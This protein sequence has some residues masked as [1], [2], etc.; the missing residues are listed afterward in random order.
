[1]AAR[2]L[3]LQAAQEFAPRSRRVDDSGV[4][5]RGLAPRRRSF[6]RHSRSAQSSWGRRLVRAEKRSKENPVKSKPVFEG[7]TLPVKASE[8]PERRGIG[9]ELSGRS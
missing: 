4:A 9:F 8:T 5:P 3:A 7:D 2:N 6:C 1:T